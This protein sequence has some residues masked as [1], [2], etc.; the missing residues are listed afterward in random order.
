MITVEEFRVLDRCS[1]YGRIWTLIQRPT[2]SNPSI[3]RYRTP[4]Y[5]FDIEALTLFSIV[6]QNILV[7]WDTDITKD[8]RPDE[9]FHL[10]D[11]L[12]IRPYSKHL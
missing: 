2:V 6:S 3:I 5:I 1:Q 9:E 7:T 8:P 11:S 10:K 12:F 4:E